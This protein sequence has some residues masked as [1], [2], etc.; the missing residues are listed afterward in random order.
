MSLSSPVRRSLLA[1]TVALI[2]CSCTTQ[3][4]PSTTEP[5]AEPSPSESVPGTAASE[6]AADV[7][8]DMAMLPLETFR[9]AYEGDER[10]LRFDTDVINNG[11]GPV[12]VTGERKN[13]MTPDL[14]VKQNILLEDGSTREVDTDAI[15]RYETFDGHE[16][17]HFQDF[18]RYRMRPEGGSEWTGS[19][20]EGWCLIDDGNLG[21]KP[22]RYNPD[23]F[24][25]GA[26]E[27]DEALEV[28]QG[29]TE[30]WVDVYDWYLEGQYIEL[31]GLEI[32]GNFCVEAE[33][34]PEKLLTEVTRD[35]NIASALVRITDTEVTI[36]RQGC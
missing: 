2:T 11:P 26:Y 23:N 35:N 12:D 19:H 13:T 34:D 31:K 24:D 22:S 36:V 14:K 16:H 15:L 6:P 18:E 29:L 30:G 32:P 20:K 1:V 25:C 7:L 8:P 5:S 33:V 21:G 17:F 4:P 28:R 3:G 10:V 9:L 27:E